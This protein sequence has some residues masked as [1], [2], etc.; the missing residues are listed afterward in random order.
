MAEKGFPLNVVLKA[1][2]KVSAPLKGIAGRIQAF[3]NTVSSVRGKFSDLSER[4]GLTNLTSKVVGLGGA[5]KGVG[6]G[7]GTAATRMAGLA[8]ATGIASG[9]LVVL[10]QAYADLTGQIGDTAERTGISRERFQELGFAAQLSGSSAE[11]LGGALQKM[12]LAVGAA[13]KGSKDLKDMFSGLGIRLKNSNGTLKTTDELFN[14][15]VDRISKI[16]D[17]SLQ[18]QAAVK[19]FGKSATEL[20]PLIRGGTA[21]LNEMADQARKLGVVISDDAVREGEEFGDVLDMVKMAMSGVGNTV[22]GILVPQLNKLGNM[23]IETIVKYRPQIEAFATAFAQNLPGNIERVTGFLGDLYN[24]IQ[25]VVTAVDWLSESVG[26]ANVVLI[27]L[28]LYIGGPLLVSLISLGTS[29]V[30]V[31]TAMSGPLMF[32]LKIAG[33]GFLALGR[34]ILLTPLGWF[35]AAIAAVGAA[36][37]I[38]YDNWEQI[39]DF[40]AQ[41]WAAVKA[42]FSD[43]IINGI[44]KVWQE[45]NP[46]T[47]MMEGFNGLIKYL[48]GWDLGAIM[49]EKITAAVSAISSSLPDWAKSLL[50]IDGAA[51]TVAATPPAPGQPVAALGQQ[52]ATAGAATPVGQRAAAIGQQAAQTAM[53]QQQA[54]RVEVDIKNAPQGTRTTT[55]GTPGAKF[56]TNIGYAMGAPN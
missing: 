51:V 40:F 49:R 19:V 56:D 7:I 55:S 47:L 32:A 31:A 35:L 50:G 48:T 43:G 3:G 2:D 20:L 33:N 16:K 14:T 24:G 44:V 27:A 46:T 45:F 17:P 11:T 42:A 38:I 5:L 29:I 21:G 37:Y 4:S 30:S 10:G 12:N 15:F 18:A 28:G 9:G 13:T 54:V 26:G 39:S 22:A 53:A 25:P 1:I 6:E 23:L 8:A 36:A 41:K 34:A 52:A